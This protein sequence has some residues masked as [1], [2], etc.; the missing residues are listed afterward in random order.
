MSNKF[1]FYY[2][3]PKST[4]ILIIIIA[5]LLTTGVSLIFAGG[6]KESASMT[7]IEVEQ[8]IPMSMENTETAVFAGGC[9]WGVEGV[10][11]RIEGVLDVVSGYSGGEAETANYS[12]IGSG[13]TGHAESVRIIYDPTLI[14][15]NTLLEVFFYVAH[16]PTELNFQGPDIGTQYRSAVFYTNETQKKLTEEYI[17]ELEKENVFNKPIVT[18]LTSLEKFYPA[19]AYHQDFLRLNPTHPYIVYW[20][21]PKIS[22]LEKMY[23]D[24]L[25]DN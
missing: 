14:S 13:N 7:K 15:Y 25:A 2:N 10:Y 20:D 23:P 9:F 3:R 5:L 11:E 17:K 18:E 1:L 16:N 19:E 22:N 21:L 12:R 8:E 4:G 24:L 6:K